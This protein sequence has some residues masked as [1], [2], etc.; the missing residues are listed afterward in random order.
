MK[1][2]S[3]FYCGQSYDHLRTDAFSSHLFQNAQKF[4]YQSLPFFSYGF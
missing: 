1:S 3:L 2:Q 4:T